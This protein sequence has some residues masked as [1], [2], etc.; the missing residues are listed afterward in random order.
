MKRRLRVC[1]EM[2]DSAPPHYAC[3]SVYQHEDTQR[4]FLPHGV[5]S[6][7]GY[8]STANKVVSTLQATRSNWAW[9]LGCGDRTDSR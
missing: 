1:P 9:F 4:M 7:N 2:L 5:Y 8:Q 6:A 3:P